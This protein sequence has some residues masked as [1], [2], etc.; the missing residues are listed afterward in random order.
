VT[1]FRILAPASGHRVARRIG[2]L[3]ASAPGLFSSSSGRFAGTEGMHQGRS[4]GVVP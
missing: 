2:A 3:N 1:R 4:S